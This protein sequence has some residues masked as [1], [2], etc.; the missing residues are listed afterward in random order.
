MTT[1]WY[2]TGAEGLAVEAK[3]KADADKPKRFWM[4]KEAMADVVFLDNESF[5]IYEFQ[6]RDGS[7]WMN[8]ATLSSDPDVSVLFKS[9]GLRPYLCAFRTI[10]NCNEWTDPKGNKHQFELQ[11]LPAKAHLADL[12]ERRKKMHNGLALKVFTVSRGKTEK[13]AASGDDYVL[14]REVT[15]PEKLYASA[16]YKGKRF[17]ELIEAAN[18]D[19][20]KLEFMRSKFQ[21]RL[22]SDGKIIP[23]LY[24]F[25]YLNLLEP[26]TLRAAKEMLASF[27]GSPDHQLQD[28][29]TPF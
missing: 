23:G 9:K 6:W 22:D 27:K 24:P 15:D 17:A 29:D 28:D 10:I 20:S 16:T 18:K 8:W 26:P 1:N 11:L 19:P 13:A 14:T 5:N 7:S 12:L 2:T 25:N 4:P 3:R 21:V